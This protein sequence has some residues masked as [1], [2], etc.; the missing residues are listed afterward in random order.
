MDGLEDKARAQFI[1]GGHFNEMRLLEDRQSHGQQ[2]SIDGLP[3]RRAGHESS[4]QH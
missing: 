1:A 4:Q 2:P 3:H